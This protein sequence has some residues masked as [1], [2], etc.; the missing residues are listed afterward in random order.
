M[1]QA[2]ALAQ[3]MRLIRTQADCGLIVYTGYTYEELTALA[4]TD[5]GLRAFLDTEDLLIDGPYVQELNDGRPYVGSS[6][7]RIIALTPRYERAVQ[8]YYEQAQSRA[9]EIRLSERGTIMMGVPSREQAQIWN[10]VKELGDS[11]GS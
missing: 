8:T 2:N 1:L 6:N 9:I 7:Q 10:K 5:E 11:H 3:M 4:Q